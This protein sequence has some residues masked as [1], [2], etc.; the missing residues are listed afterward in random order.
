MFETLNLL[1]KTRLKI[2]RINQVVA[3]LAALSR[4]LVVVLILVVVAEYGWAALTN[5]RI[6][7]AKTQ[8]A[9]LRNQI[10]DQSSTEGQYLY[11][12]QVLNTA[13]A[14]VEKRKNFLESLNELY[15]RLEPGVSIEG[16]QFSDVSLIFSGKA[17]NVQVFSQTLVN[18]RNKPAETLFGDIVLSSSSRDP[19]GSYHFKVEIELLNAPSSFG[20]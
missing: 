2:T 11:Y 3:V 13:T 17:P 5:Q 14:I 12:Q 9:S 20:S 1:P 16:I 4:V 8:I 6:N 10:S 19:N 18:F 15:N 7:A